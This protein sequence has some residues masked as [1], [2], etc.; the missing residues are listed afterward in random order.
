MRI[1]WF[2]WARTKRNA[3]AKSDIVS[4]GPWL[5]VGLGNPGTK[6]EHTRHNAG[7]WLLDVL[8][9]TWE[10]PAW[11]SDT[12]ANALVSRGQFP[13][14]STSLLL[15]FPQTFMNESGQAVHALLRFFRIPLDRLIVLHDEK[16]LHLG[17][18]KLQRNRS[19]AGHKGVQSVIDAVGSQDFW[20]LRIGVGVAEQ[21]QPTDQFVLAPF[22]KDEQDLLSSSIFPKGIKEVEGFLRTENNQ[23]A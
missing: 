10:L 20:R 5:L 9:T 19:A 4:E 12:R 2:S 6:Y 3:S 17:E 1:S 23:S 22:G 15:A 13:G 14:T 7:A 18:L 21:T 11:Q 16:D 8:R